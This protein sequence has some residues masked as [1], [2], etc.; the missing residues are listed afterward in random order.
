MNSEDLDR[1]L[2]DLRYLK[3]DHQT[4]EAKEA[5]DALPGDIDQTMSAFA[6][7]IGG[8]LLLGVKEGLTHT[9]EVTGVNDPSKLQT[10]LQNQSNLMEPPL[11]PAIGC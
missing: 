6:N 3:N 10:D 11:R 8:V 1:L 9:F 5:F 2:A 4:A 7:G